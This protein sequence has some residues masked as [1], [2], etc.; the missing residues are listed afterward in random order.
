MSLECSRNTSWEC[1]QCL[2]FSELMWISN[3]AP[4]T[5]DLFFESLLSFICF[6]LPIVQ[7]I[8]TWLTPF[9]HNAIIALPISPVMALKG[10]TAMHVA[11]SHHCSPSLIPALFPVHSGMLW[12]GILW[13]TSFIKWNINLCNPSIFGL[14][15][16]IRYTQLINI[17]QCSIFI[18]IISEGC[19]LRKAK[20]DGKKM[21]LQLKAILN[22][23]KTFS[24]ID[25]S[26][27]SMLQHNLPVLVACIP[28]K[29]HSTG[30]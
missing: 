24:V 17:F 28:P 14:H 27:S 19:T 15:S 21:C 16:T 10:K 12:S 30:S 29:L 2:A 8:L 23:K 1:I 13:G 5:L 18:P 4:F 26:S 9:D 11:H 20:G 7:S 22:R 6:A 3:L 25:L